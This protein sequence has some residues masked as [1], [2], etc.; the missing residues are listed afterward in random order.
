MDRIRHVCSSQPLQ[1]PDVAERRTALA[2]VID[3]LTTLHR[4]PLPPEDL[5]RC[6][7]I[8]TRAR[9]AMM[10]PTLE[11]CARILDLADA[12]GDGA[13]EWT[14]SWD[15]IL[16][17]LPAA[18][19]VLVRTHMETEGVDVRDALVAAHDR[20]PRLFGPALRTALTHVLL[21]HSQP[22]TARS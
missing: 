7:Q 21:A 17:R 10:D 11:E 3:A 12:R 15:E 9:F 14:A 6:V 1:S 18:A 16:E 22:M 5:N 20:Y 8:M 19:Q 2:A 4:E 13:V